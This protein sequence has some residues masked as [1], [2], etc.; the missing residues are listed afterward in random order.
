[1][2]A[3]HESHRQVRTP[4]IDMTEIKGRGSAE[5]ES[6]D[7]F[8]SL[9]VVLEK[10]DPRTEILHI[11]GDAPRNQEWEILAHHFTSVRFL[12]IATGWEENWNDGKFPLN[13]PL[14]L[15]VIADSVGERIT[16]PAIMEGRIPS[17]V[18]LFTAG[19]RFE[20]PVTEELMKNAEQLD[21][22]PRKEKEDAETRAETERSDSTPSE[23]DGT[24][25]SISEPAAEAENP[26]PQAAKS[27]A[28]PDGIKVYSVP[29]EWSKW[30]NN[31][32]EG[33]A[34]VF[35]PEPG[36]ASPPS[37]MRDLQILGND[38]LQ[39]LSYVALAKFHLLSSLESL[40]VYSHDHNDLLHIPHNIPLLF[41]P[42]L[43]NLTTFKLTLGGAM[44]AK[45]AK[46]AD[47]EPFLHVFL[48]PNVEVLR[49][50]GPVS[51]A[52]HLEEFAAAFEYEEFLPRL[53]KISFVL[54]L[55]DKSSDFQRE[56]SLEQLR[57]AHKAC[58][59]VLDAAA[60]K[61]GAVEEAFREPWVEE[62]A[63]LFFEVDN[64]WGVLDEMARV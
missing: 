59:R 28:E 46:L 36:D 9:Q 17:L 22:Y 24:P 25:S 50:R 20:G 55:P 18:L 15:L 34:I 63:G 44:Y 13:W 35:S 7:A 19:L 51:M 23:A 5:Q 10:I 37:S 6:D 33:K 30:I 31:H 39:M 27:E 52:P 57:A 49:C 38:A 3:G 64:R 40:T 54:D 62:H 32:Y 26:E 42:L 58:R 8:D 21:F 16:T 1:M 14:E 2:A 61:R 45:L 12:K 60:T 4:V 56:P 41:L 48:P 47:N 53:K 43:D 11:V 29:Y